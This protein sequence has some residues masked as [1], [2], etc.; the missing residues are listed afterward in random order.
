[1]SN[2]L[3]LPLLI[4]GLALAL[5][6]CNNLGNGNNPNPDFSLS[7][8]PSS[9]KAVEDD[10]KGATF[11]V[12]VNRTGGFAGDIEVE[13]VDPPAFIG[14]SAVVPRTGG[15]ATI[16]AGASS[17]EFRITST[18]AGT[19]DLTLRGVG[20]GLTRTASLKLEV[21]KPPVPDFSFSLEPTRLQVKPGG[22]A[23]FKVTLT[24]Q[25]GFDEEVLFVFTDEPQGLNV[26]LSAGGATPS[27]FCQNST[28]TSG[29]FTVE[30]GSNVDEGTYNLVLEGLSASLTRTANLE[31]RVV[32]VVLP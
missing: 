28:S 10:L 15:Q 6:G 20:G 17:K 4:L 18:E 24:C 8:D 26:T 31:L 2:V 12:S 23:D 27:L 30:V 14:F 22:S 19:F 13:L 5:L 7:L 25:G 32:R 1:M 29:I 16:P 11:T 21:V 3:K 9:L